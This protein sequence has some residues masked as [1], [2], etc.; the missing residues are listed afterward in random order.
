[1]HL[2]ALTCPR[3]QAAL[4]FVPAQARLLAFRTPP[5]PAEP[6]PTWQTGALWGQPPR[7]LRPCAN[8]LPHGVCNWMLDPGDASTLCR[9]C[10][11]T[12]LIPDLS[13][14]GNLA[15][16]RA[17]EAAKRQALLSLARMGLALEANDPGAPVPPPQF[18][19]I[20]RGPD[21]GAAITSHADGVITIDLA[22]AD[23]LHRTQQRLQFGEPQRTLL[24][25]LRH[26]LG[27]YLQ[28]RFVRQPALQALCRDSFGDERQDYQ[29]AL[30]R[31]HSEGPPGD[32]A[33]AHISAY[34]SAHPLEDWAET[35]AHLIAAWEA[36]HTAMAWRLNML[37][38]PQR[39]APPQR[40]LLQW[41]SADRL[42]S[43]HWL[44]L[45]SCLD[46]MCASLGLSAPYPYAPSPM[47]LRKLGAVQKILVLAT[48]PAP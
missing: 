41:P 35:C 47:V 48:A 4:G 39:V 22:E 42:F 34:A 19:F 38:G 5:D 25:H 3:C 30:A 20:E 1:V 14:P 43:T 31:H 32:W 12:T 10:R 17:M 6:W 18:R 45:A 16:W 15:H 11:L 9:S 7:R 28:Y 33:E 2:Q 23:E 36:V 29:Q 21:A 37:E 46:G 26:E 27:H 40:L 8:R 24:G 44:P 13:R